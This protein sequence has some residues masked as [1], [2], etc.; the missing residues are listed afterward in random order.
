MGGCAS[1]GADIE[2][3]EHLLTCPD[4]RMKAVRYTAMVT[5]RSSIVTKLG[6]TCAWDT[7]HNCLLYWIH[8]RIDPP[9]QILMSHNIPSQLRS[10]LQQAIIDQREIGWSAAFQ[11]FLSHHWLI[12]QQWSHPRSTISGLQRQWLVPIIQAIWKA[13]IALWDKRNE[14]L[15]AASDTTRIICESS[16]NAKIQ[17]LYSIKE[18]FATSDQVLFSVPMEARLTQTKR[19]KRTWLCLVAHYHPTT[20]A[21][22]K[23]NQPL[24]TKFFSRNQGSGPTRSSTDTLLRPIEQ[25]VLYP[26]DSG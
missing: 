16:I 5:L 7:L 19:E 18:T 6:G 8:N 23:G 3:F 10:T 13:T 2:T 14:I 22:Q 17:H 15:H 20:K 12:A 1:C 25:P 24:I 4:N 9:F 26:D 21:R 11:G